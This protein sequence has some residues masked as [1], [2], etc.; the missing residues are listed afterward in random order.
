[1]YT[2]HETYIY[3]IHK[4]WDKTLKSGQ[5][6]ASVSTVIIWC[7]YHTFALRGIL[8]AITQDVDLMHCSKRLEKLFEF[9]F[10]PGARDLSHKHLDGIWV[11]LVQ[12][13]QRPIHLA[14]VAKIKPKSVSILQC[15]KKKKQK[16]TLL[17][18]HCQFVDL[19]VGQRLLQ[20]I[21]ND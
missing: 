10:R 20:K 9:C 2:F 6:V 16:Q 5:H 8:G 12:V 3:H 18:P 17:Q 15:L 21:Y 7:F 13:L 19:F 11:W 1:M 4:R 14:A